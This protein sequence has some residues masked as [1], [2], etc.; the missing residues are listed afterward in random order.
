MVAGNE[1]RSGSLATKAVIAEAAAHEFLLH[2]YAGSSLSSIADRLGLTKGALVYHFPAKADFA[3]YLSDV[4]RAA[5]EQAATHA[6]AEYPECGA[7]RIVLHYLV[8]GSWRAAEPQI[9]AGM[10]LFGDRG[11][12]VFEYPVVV[13]D[14]LALI[15]DALAE[16]RERGMFADD[17]DLGEAAQM[18]QVT[19][20]GLVQFGRLVGVDISE[21]KLMR[22]TAMAMTS[23]GIPDAPRHVA[24]VVAAH[25]GRLPR[26]RHPAGE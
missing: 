12:P 21:D 8:M 10:A 5:M 2:G 22:F 14:A 18:F 24:D 16:C 6:R 3:A 25:R 9:D 23:V 15:T 20:L 26:F 11:G 17:W 1:R 4:V 13:R 19:T 7:C